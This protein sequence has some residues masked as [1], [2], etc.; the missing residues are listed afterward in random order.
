VKPTFVPKGHDMTWQEYF[1]HC[2][3][4][5]AAVPEV[6]RVAEWLASQPSDVTTQVARAGAYR[7]EDLK[8]LLLRLKEPEDLRA[9]EKAR[10]AAVEIRPTS[11]HEPLHLYHHRFLVAQER[12]GGPREFS[13]GVRRTL[14][15]NSLEAVKHRA[16]VELRVLLRRSDPD[17][18]WPLSTIM[19]QAVI[20]DEAEAER[21]AQRKGRHENKPPHIPSNDRPHDRHGGGGWKPSGGRSGNQGRQREERAKM[22]R[23]R[24]GAT[25]DVVASQRREYLHVHVAGKR[26][27]CL[28]DTGASRNFVSSTLGKAPPSR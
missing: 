18:Q 17:E 16:L 27:A 1:H 6:N 2:E 11:D 10:I 7:W 24:A 12:A 13:D 15:L 23:E 8:R 28:V 19:E 4:L 20:L 5:L 25:S 3:F 26:V 14:Y 21:A 9:R 22:A